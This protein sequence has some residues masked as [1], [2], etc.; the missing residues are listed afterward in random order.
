MVIFLLFYSVIFGIATYYPLVRELEEATHFEDQARVATV[1]LGLEETV[2]PALILVLVLVFI[3]TIL[4]SH[5]VTGPIYRL[6]RAIEE[7]VSGNLKERIRL[8]KT[9]EFKE[10]ET[11]VN[12][13]AE[14]LEN[15]QSSD[16]RFHTD[17]RE[18]LSTV[19]TMLN[20]EGQ[21]SGEQARKILDEV[22]LKLDSQ[23]D[24]FTAYKK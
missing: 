21:S 18:K 12:K 24:A 5:R 1:M 20:S 2:W 3:G 10:I 22:I 23:P 19:S 8:R 13:L 6:E 17:L 16:S 11:M 4:F 15:V 14:Y 9:D 7:F